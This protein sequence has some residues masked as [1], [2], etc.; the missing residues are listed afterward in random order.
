MSHHDVVIVGLGPVGCTAAIL[1]AQAGL[2][3]AVVERDRE[4]YRLP[5][6]VNLDAELIRGF[7][8]VG[9]GQQVADLM[10][11]LRPGDRAGF[12]NSSRE[13]LFGQE[14][15]S[16]GGNGWQPMNMF[17]QP[18]LEQYLRDQALAQAGVRAFIGYEATAIDNEADQVR[19]TVAPVE[20]QTPDNN[21][22]QTLTAQYLVACDGAA[23]FTRK[24]FGIGW[25]DLGY[26]HD[27]LV[28]DII[29]REG[30]TLGNDTLQVCDPER[31]VTYVCTKD[32]YRRWEFKLLPGETA[33]Q[34]LDESV[35]ESL[36]EPW[37]PK[38]TYELRRA[39]VYQFH[40]A[41][42][43]R[44]RVGRVFIAGDAAHQTPPF[45]GQ[46]MNAGM[47]D[48]VNLAWKLP[49]VI[50]GTA[51]DQLLE[52][53][54]AER[55]AHA[56]DLVEWAVSIGRLMEHLAETERCQRDGLP[57]PSA[58]QA[59]QS[60]GYGQGR[61]APPLRDGVV[62]LDQVSDTG[63]TGYLFRQ[64]IVR[65]E[66]G[67]ELRLDE[68]LGPGFALVL[69]S[70]DITEPLLSQTSRETL[71]RIGGRIVS[72]DQLEPV[73]GSIDRLFETADAAIVRPDRIVFGHTTPTLSVNE[74]I[75]T[76][77]D[78]LAL[79]NNT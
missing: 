37:T 72:L 34:M 38:G 76:L 12:A 20:N 60:S 16:F 46:G 14:L 73:R 13:W 47:R 22:T 43:D 28:V 29:A 6:A 9:L 62:M 1:F 19:V 24:S 11:P 35:I 65:D 45:L 18:E 10:Q 27:W 63:S 52:S 2:T 31:I 67:N 4:V 51:D 78:K 25:Q 8:R 66:T 53:Y 75:V 64:P 79:T 74:L 5:R 3:V 36:I 33:E 26:N 30:H 15:K 57:E 68:L 58:P 70:A 55:N 44:W 61:E 21:D 17:D 59:L 48:V 71:A 23:S 69:K 32:P 7:Q 49:M 42:A 56:H 40:A 39:A 54:F 77:A 41:T 50:Q